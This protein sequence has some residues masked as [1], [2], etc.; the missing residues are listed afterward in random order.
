M[1]FDSGR[2]KYELLDHW[3]KLP[4]G[5]SFNTAVAMSIDSKDRVFVYSRHDTHP[6]MVFDRDGNLVTSWGEGWFS[7]AHGVFVGPDDNVYCA[8]MGNH[9]VSK[10]TP[11]GKLLLTLGTK[12]VPSDT[13]Y[14]GILGIKP[15]HSYYE[16]LIIASYCFAQKRIG[17]PFNRPTGVFVTPAG[18]IWVSDGYGNAQIHR[19]SPEGKLLSS[20]GVLGD[21]LGE[22]ICPHGVWVDK[23]EQVWVTDRVNCRVQ[24]FDKQGKYIRSIGELSQ[25]AHAYIDDEETVFIPECLGL[26]LAMFTLEGKLLARWHNHELNNVVP[27]TYPHVTA[28]DSK[29]DL[30]FVN[31][32]PAGGGFYKFAKIS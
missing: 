12:D 17:P 22:F 23:Q 9:T 30:Y 10:W 25:P 7:R 24:I 32:P 3:G 16:K 27:F 28:V 1:I 6:M 19:F 4:A 20:W 31:A 11:E 2:H 15:Q 21:G 13:G 29:G 8:D 26:S 14:A 18:E 5:V